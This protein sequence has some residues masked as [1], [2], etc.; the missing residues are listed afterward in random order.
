[1]KATTFVEVLKRVSINDLA[2]HIVHLRGA[3]DLCPLTGEDGQTFTTSARGIIPGNHLLVYISNADGANI[4]KVMQNI[5]FTVEGEMIPDAIC[6]DPE[7]QIIAIV[8]ID[9]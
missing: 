1:M 5:C 2:A 9:E 4:Y 8:K 7:G 6:G 3:D